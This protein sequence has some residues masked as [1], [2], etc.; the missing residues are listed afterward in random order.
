MTPVFSRSLRRRHASRAHFWRERLE[1]VLTRTIPSQHAQLAEHGILEFADAAAAAAAAALSRATS[2]DFTDA[3]LLGLRR[4]QMDRGGEL[5][6]VA[7]AR[8]RHRGARSTRSS[9]TSKRR[10]RRTAISTAGISAASPRSAGPTCATTTSSTCAGHLLEGAI[11]YFQATG[12]RRLLDIMERYVDHIA[13][14]VRP[15]PGPEAR[16]LRPPGDRAGADQALPPDRRPQAPRPR[17]L[18]HRRARQRSRTTSTSRRSRA[19]T[20]RRSSGRRPTNTTS[21]TSRCASRTRSSATRCAPCTCTPRWPT[22]PPSSSDDSAEARLRDAV[23]R[24]HRRRRCTSPPAS[25]PSAANEGFTEDYDLPN[26][27]AYAETCASVALIFWAQRMLHLDLDGTYADVWSWRSSTARCPAC[28]ATASTTSTQNPLESDGTPQ[29]WDWHTCPCCTMNVSRLVASVGGYFYLDRRRTRSPSTSTAAAPPTVDGRRH[30]RS[31]IAGDRATIPGRATIRI[32]VDPE[33]P[34]RVHAEA[35]H[36][37]L[38]A[39][40]DGVRSTASRSTSPATAAT[41]MST[42]RAAL[43]RRR[44]GRPRP[45][46]AGRAHLRPPERAAWTSAASR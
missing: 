2:H 37:R 29:R 27:T 16:L 22:S 35:A 3:G 32:A 24:R 1:T 12:R 17:R 5:C 7:P 36:P 21:R 31:R 33:A 43:E 28:R 14:D 42:I 34:A 13:R 15:G 39:R 41:A 46:D 30:A 38:G 9:T 25:G 6:A 26:D 19:A 18:L 8:R 40:R 11:A 10:R 20:T 4:R 23:G 44:H 45:A